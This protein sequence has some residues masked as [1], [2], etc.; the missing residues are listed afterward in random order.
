MHAFINSPDCLEKS[1][2]RVPID[3]YGTYLGAPWISQMRTCKTI[4]KPSKK[5]HLRGTHSFF[6]IL[7]IFGLIRPVLVHLL[8]IAFAMIGAQWKP[9]EGWWRQ[10]ERQLWS[11]WVPTL[12]SQCLR[13]V[14]LTSGN[15]EPG[16]G[17]GWGIWPPHMRVMVTAGIQKW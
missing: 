9:G 1:I 2:R 15:S 17:L 6:R 12:F 7:S 16:G 10:V 13:I 4:E 5:K 14:Y 11:Q 8:L 3:P